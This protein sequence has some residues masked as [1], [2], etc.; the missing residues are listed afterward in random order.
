MRYGT[1]Y[2]YYH[3]CDLVLA[4]RVSSTDD[5][6]VSSGASTVNTQSAIDTNISLIGFGFIGL[7]LIGTVIYAAL[8]LV[9]MRKR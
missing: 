5:I 4:Y 2:R 6:S 9:F 1:L 3:R 8:V 7:A